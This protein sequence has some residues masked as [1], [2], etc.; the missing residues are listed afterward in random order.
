MR[1]STEQRGWEKLSLNVV[2]RRRGI[3]TFQGACV[4]NSNI[5]CCSRMCMHVK[6]EHLLL[7]W[8]VHAYQIWTFS[9]AHG[10]SC[11]SNLNI[12]CCTRMCMHIKFGH[13]LLHMDVHACKILTSSVAYECACMSNLNIFGCTCM[14]GVRYKK[15]L[16]GRKCRST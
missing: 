1:V 11:M 2:H 8:D 16:H 7:H 5:F 3:T 6:F 9:V 14:L 15:M 4:S 12:F 13:L 10:C